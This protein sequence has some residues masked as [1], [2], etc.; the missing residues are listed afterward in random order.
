M[1]FGTKDKLRTTGR[2][3][4]SG[5]D[6]IY[7]NLSDTISGISSGRNSVGLLVFILYFSFSFISGSGQTVG[8]FPNCTKPQKMDFIL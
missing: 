4:V 6:E 2:F 1:N 5:G 7:P 3:C 8:Q